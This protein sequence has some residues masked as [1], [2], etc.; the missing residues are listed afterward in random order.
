[1]LGVGGPS[2]QFGSTGAGVVGIAGG[3]IALRAPLE[4]NSGV[5]GVGSDN[6][7]SVISDGVV[8]YAGPGGTGVV[9][10]DDW[11]GDPNSS[12]AG[13]FNGKV[14]AQ[15][16]FVGADFSVVG[17]KSAVVP[18]P[19]GT[20]R[21]L[22]CMESPECWF[23]DFGTGELVDGQAQ[24][25]LDPGF[26]AVVVTDN[27]HVFLTEYEDNNALYVT[28]RTSTGFVVR[29][30]ASPSAS[31]TF[32]YRVVARRKDITPL[33]FEEVTLTAPPARPRREAA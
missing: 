14:W 2:D 6:P 13:V 12:F 7:G 8:G 29:A 11:S 17:P 5:I 3:G 16:L 32:S 21:R 31:G 28:A 33:R 23:E 18:F 10:W 30:K 22:Y 1:V 27:Y 4:R 9:G 26:A 20:Q 25:Q 24:V 19:D 15:S